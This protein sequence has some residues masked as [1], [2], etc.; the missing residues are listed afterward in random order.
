[1]YSHSKVER[2]R[3]LRLVLN[4]PTEKQLYAKFKKCEFWIEH[5]LFLGH[6]ISKEG[7]AVYPGK[8]KVVKN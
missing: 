5:V 3:H 4:I 7:I 8:I 2:E 1:M 6:I